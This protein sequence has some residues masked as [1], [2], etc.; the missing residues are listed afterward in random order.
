MRNP[1]TLIKITTIGIAVAVV[2]GYALFEIRG[3]LIGPR[4]V[5]TSHPSGSVL[6]ESR[7]TLA[8]ETERVTDITL[9]DRPIFIDESGKWSE[10]VILAP[11][12]N[13][14][15][16]NAHDRFGRVDRELV[17]LVYRAPEPPP[18]PPKESTTTATT[19]EENT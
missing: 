15:E 10:A 16:L 12:Y 4:V 8:G 3:L 2:A 11:G 9:N 17:E 6:N 14:L 19:S 5:V 18:A 7:I 13:V 1:R